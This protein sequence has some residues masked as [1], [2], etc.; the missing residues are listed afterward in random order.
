MLNVDDSPY[1]DDFFGCQI[2]KMFLE[3]GPCKLIIIAKRQELQ[4]APRHSE[5]CHHNG[6]HA[7][8]FN[9]NIQ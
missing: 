9:Q 1:T 3:T 2:Y 8:Q 5:P 4:E 6:N 7:H